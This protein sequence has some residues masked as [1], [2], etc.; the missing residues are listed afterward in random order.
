MESEGRVLKALSAIFREFDPRS[1]NQFVDALA[2][3]ASIVEILEGVQT[4]PLEI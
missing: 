3:L 1:Q 4:Q 2:T